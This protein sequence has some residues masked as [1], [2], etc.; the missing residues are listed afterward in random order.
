MNYPNPMYYGYPYQQPYYSY[1]PFNINQ[2]TQEPPPPPPTNQPPQHSS[3]QQNNQHH[4]EDKKSLYFGNIDEKIGNEIVDYLQSSFKFERVTRPQ[5]KNYMFIGFSTEEDALHAK[6]SI[7]KSEKFKEKNIKINFGKLTKNQQ[8]PIQTVNV[9]AYAQMNP[10]MPM[11]GMYPYNMMPPM[12][13]NPM[14]PPMQQMPYDQE[15]NNLNNSYQNNQSKPNGKNNVNTSYNN[16]EKQLQKDNNKDEKISKPIREIKQLND[17]NEQT[18]RKSLNEKKETDNKETKINDKE[19]EKDN[20]YDQE[21]EYEREN[22]DQMM[23]QQMPPQYPIP[24]MYPQQIPHQPMYPPPPMNQM[25]QGNGYYRQHQNRNYNRS[26]GNNY[27]QRNQYQHHS[28]DYDQS[29]HRDSREMR[30]SREYHQRENRNGREY[31]R[32]YRDNREMKENTKENIKERKEIEVTNMLWIGDLKENEM[33][34]FSRL[35]SYGPIKSIQ[36][37]KFK[38]YAFIEYE[39]KEDARKAIDENIHVLLKEENVKIRYAREFT[40]K[41]QLWFPPMPS[42]YLSED[43]LPLQPMN[44]EDCIDINEK[45]KHIIDEM[46]P[47]LHQH[48]ISFEQKVKEEM[49]GKEEFQFLFE[50]SIENDYYQWKVYEYEMMKMNM[51]LSCQI[52]EKKKRDDIPPWLIESEEDEFEMKEEKQTNELKEDIENFDVNEQKEH[53]EEIELVEEV[54]MEEE[55]Q[56]DTTKQNDKIIEENQINDLFD[57]EELF[58]NFDQLDQL[59]SNEDSKTMEEP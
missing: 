31:H 33:K 17:M 27:N 13:M 32:E 54:S 8:L 2:T 30:D 12:Y 14:M 58:D 26:N 9:N 50:Q 24:P 1:V 21:K 16:Q 56:N 40:G 5:G 53:L 52:N 59:D 10:M 47:Y 15:Y 4:M 48:G 22:Y 44:E 51:I 55:H 41:S 43:K 46:L 57:E 39:N 7:L 37:V 11:N 45:T 3:N 29:N 36:T 34:V 49:K 38:N 35:T 18:P 25:N 42:E 19:R 23:Y 20:Q 6:E 28:N